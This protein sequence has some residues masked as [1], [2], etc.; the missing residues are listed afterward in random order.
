MSIGWVLASLTNERSAYTILYNYNPDRW[1]VGIPDDDPAPDPEY[2]GQLPQGPHPPLRGGNVVD[3][4]D[5]EDSVKAVI[6]VRKRHV[7]TDKYLQ[8][9][10][11][12]CPVLLKSSRHLIVLFSSDLGE[13][14]TAV[15]SDVE[16]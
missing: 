4:S 14:F 13:V 11:K 12:Y 16:Q 9:K 7:I 2:P 6:F 5:G 1:E 10:V 8:I 3:H 15:N